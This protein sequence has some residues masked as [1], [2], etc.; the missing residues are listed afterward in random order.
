VASIAPLEIKA[1]VK[2]LE[3]LDYYQILHLEPDAPASA[4]KRA[5][6][7]TSRTFHPDANRH[8]DEELRD[9]CARISKRVTEA[10]C[11]LRDPRRRQA[12]DEKLASGGRRMQL[13]EAKAAHVKK[14]VETRQGRTPQGRQF[15]QKA[16]QDLERGNTAGAV[17]NLRMALT[18]EPD[19]AFFKEQLA[20]L[21]ARQR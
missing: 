21:K 6:H 14:Q 2:I 13:A 7:A 1:L 17:N 12:Y 11:V 4:V 19:N 8:L 10:Y 9:G 15:Y 18:F 16:Q 20:A 3:E 5:F